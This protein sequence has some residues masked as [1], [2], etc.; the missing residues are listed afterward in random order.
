MSTPALG[1]EALFA[2][3][4]ETFCLTL[5]CNYI[6]GPDAWTASVEDF[7]AG[8]TRAYTGESPVAAVMH[9]V[10]K[11]ED[12]SSEFRKL[13]EHAAVEV[14]PVNRAPEVLSWIQS[15]GFYRF[16]MDWSGETTISLCAYEADEGV[17]FRRDTLDEAL[18]L[19]DRF[20]TEVPC[21]DDIGFEA[22]ERAILAW[23]TENDPRNSAAALPPAVEERES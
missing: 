2:R 23:L 6:G 21:P 3:A 11:D 8:E 22:C 7:G 13:A 15:R 16:A 17:E 14:T 4:I 18:E 12:V 20:E 9:F 1:L 5:H 10:A 19:I